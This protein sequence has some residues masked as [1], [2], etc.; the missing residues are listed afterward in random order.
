MRTECEYIYHG[1][2]GDKN[3]CTLSGRPCLCVDEW[4]H[5]TRRQ[6]AQEY[7]QKHPK[8]KEWDGVMLTDGTGH[9][10]DTI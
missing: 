4:Q 7:E 2:L 5:C 9:V 6:Y 8:T 1:P 3:T 10:T